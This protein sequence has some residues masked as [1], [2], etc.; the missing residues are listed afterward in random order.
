MI[1]STQRSNPPPIQATKAL[2][3]PIPGRQPTFEE[4]ADIAIASAVVCG[5]SVCVLCLTQD[6]LERWTCRLEELTAPVTL[7]DVL[8][9]NRATL[10]DWEDFLSSQTSDITVLHGAR[11]ELQ[12]NRLSAGYVKALVD[13][14]P[15]GLVMVA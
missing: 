10:A 13:A 3:I 4:V 7:L 14:I 6:V 15:S 1:P 2:V 12:A 9:T 8:N 11:S 5:Q